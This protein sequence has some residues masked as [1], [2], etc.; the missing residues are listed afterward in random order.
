MARTRA[1]SYD[2]EEVRADDL[3][4]GDRLAL[5]DEF[6]HPPLWTILTEEMA[7]FFGLMV[8]DGWVD[9]AAERICFTNNNPEL[10]RRV[11][12]LWSR[13]FVGTSYEW[14]GR[15]GFDPEATVGK[16]NLNGDGAYV[17]NV[18]GV[19]YRLVSPG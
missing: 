13:L 12:E 19:G 7:E 2:S 6:P 11:A 3:E 4:E 18:W 9:R 15:S 8:A 1:F 5:C 16:L 10:R 17:V 14:M